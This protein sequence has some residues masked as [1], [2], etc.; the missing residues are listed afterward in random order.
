FGVR[1][2]PWVRRCDSLASES[3][4]DPSLA[5]ELAEA[6]DRVGDVEGPPAWPN[7]GDT[8]GALRSHRIA[9]GLR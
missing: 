7:L 8:A 2:G 9:L 5:R 6:Y 3:S 4:Q 1:N